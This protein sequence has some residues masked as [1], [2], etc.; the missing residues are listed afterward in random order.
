[1]LLDKLHDLQ[2]IEFI[3]Y[4]IILVH[5]ITTQ[6]QL[7][8]NNPFSTIMQFPYDWNH[9]VMWTS[10]FIHSSKFNTLHYEDFLAI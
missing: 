6:L 3:V 10:F 1:M 5:L 7:C 9:N 4:V 8:R 2:K